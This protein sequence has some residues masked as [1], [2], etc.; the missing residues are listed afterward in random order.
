MLFR[1][2]GFFSNQKSEYFTDFEYFAKR[3]FPDNW[4]DG[5]GGVFN[6]LDRRFYNASDT[7]VQNHLMYESP[8]LILNL[9]PAISK[10][11]VTER[12][13]LSHLYNPHIRSY[14]ELGYG[15]GNSF[16]NAAVFGSFHKLKF[17]EL[18]FKIS[19]NIF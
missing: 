5:I 18:G 2:M 11:I 15:I 9:V 1:S 16:L 12:L 17:H 3:N 19:L 7:Y 14:T 13:Y 6:L 8:F 10:G 4:E